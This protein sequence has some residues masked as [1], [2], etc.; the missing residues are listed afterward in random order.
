MVNGQSGGTGGGAGG[1]GGGGGGSGGS[2]R[3]DP[4]K[5][6]NVTLSWA[7]ANSSVDSC[8]V[9]KDTDPSWKKPGASSGSIVDS[10]TTQTT[11]TVDCVNSQGAHSKKSVVVNA[12]VGYEEF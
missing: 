9:T 7:P 2:L 4:T 11:Y 1:S 5:A 6:N 8:V 12:L 10:V 3:V